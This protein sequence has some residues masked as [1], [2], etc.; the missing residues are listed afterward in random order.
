MSSWVGLGGWLSSNGEIN[1]SILQAG[2]QQGINIPK[3]GPIPFT[4]GMS[5]W[6]EWYPNNTAYID[7]PVMVG[8]SLAVFVFTKPT[9]KSGVA[10][11]FNE[12]QGVFT[13]F[14]ITAPSLIPNTAE[15]VVECPGGEEFALPDFGSVTF[16]TGA[17]PAQDASF[18]T[19]NALNASGGIALQMEDSY[20]DVMATS[21]I[22]DGTV[23]VT[24]EYAGQG[25]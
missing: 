25:V 3:G 6:T 11:F 24:W 15:W 21:E 16:E 10:W 2:V 17:T 5:A 13:A 23:T 4:T 12:T 8:D 9:S 14:A 22:V 18:W 1:T 7:F 20:G 19:L